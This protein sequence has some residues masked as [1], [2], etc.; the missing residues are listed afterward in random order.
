MGMAKEWA[1]PF[2]NSKA[3]KRTRKAYINSVHYQCE[4]CGA[5]GDELHHKIRLTPTNIN[6]PDFTLDWSNL[7]Y[8][9]FTC[10]QRETWQRQLSGT[11]QPGY[12]FDNEGNIVKVNTRVVI[13]WGPPASGKT[14]YVKNNKKPIDIVWDFDYILDALYMGQRPWAHDAGMTAIMSMREAFYQSIKNIHD[15]LIT[16]WIIGL[17]PTSKERSTLQSMF[18]AEMIHIDIT[19]ENAINHAMNDGNRTNKAQQK[20]IIEKYFDDVEA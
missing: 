12:S 11:I 13:V 7:E 19:K 14:T 3:W 18:D 16:V 10:H 6:D 2:Y 20:M 1:K 4:R 17:L 5:P 9:C 8:L 15:P